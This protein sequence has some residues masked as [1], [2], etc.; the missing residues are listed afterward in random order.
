MLRILFGP[1]TGIEVLGVRT[2]DD[3]VIVIECALSINLS[4]STIEQVREKAGVTPE[5]YA[6][7]SWNG[8]W[9]RG[10]LRPACIPTSVA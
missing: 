10:S 7:Y 9:N 3:T 2:E 8:S 6:G 5:G 1:L 4:S